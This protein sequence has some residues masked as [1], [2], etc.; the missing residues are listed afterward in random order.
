M[1]DSINAKATVVSEIS[2]KKGPEIQ[3]RDLGAKLFS[4]YSLAKQ[5]KAST[6]GIHGSSTSFWKEID[7]YSTT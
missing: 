2:Q 6:F 4:S 5:I 3:P 1:E 7:I